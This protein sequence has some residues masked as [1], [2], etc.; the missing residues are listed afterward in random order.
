MKKTIDRFY[1]IL[2]SLVG[3]HRQ[4]LDLVRIEKE[5]L[6]QAEL[7]KV[8]ELTAAKEVI[9]GS[10]QQA[11]LDRQK[12]VAE[13]SVI[14]K[15]PKKDLTL[16]QLI[17]QVQ[18]DYPKEAEQYRSAMSAMTILIQRITEQS[19]ESSAL[20]EKSLEHLSNMKANVLRE[21]GHKNEVYSK[22]G[23]KVQPSRE[24]RLLSREA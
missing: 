11:E 8:Q 17:I 2:E 12:M 16:S 21:Q 9:L 14:Y 15:I 20:I 23:N 7:K 10:I 19:K 6:I 1:E 24:S 22:S 13:F 5:A 18:G 4:L 3:F